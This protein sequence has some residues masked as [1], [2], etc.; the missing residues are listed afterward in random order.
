M[1]S[2]N[3]GLSD[4]IKKKFMLP[5]TIELHD[6]KEKVFHNAKVSAVAEF[7]IVMATSHSAILCACVGAIKGT[8]NVLL[9]K[10]GPHYTSLYLVL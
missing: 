7:I 9:S 6:P 10:D 3:D 2:M 4:D 5:L 8:D 1:W